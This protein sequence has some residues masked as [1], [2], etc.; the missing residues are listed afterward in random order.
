MQIQSIIAQS[1]SKKTNNKMCNSANKRNQAYSKDNSSTQL[2]DSLTSFGSIKQNKIIQK[3]PFA[4]LMLPVALGLSAL[5]I[6]CQQAT[7]VK[8]VDPIIVTPTPAEGN[9]KY[10]ASLSDREKTVALKIEDA[11]MAYEQVRNQSIPLDKIL[12]LSKSIGV[13]NDREAEIVSERLAIYLKD[14][15][16]NSN[17]ISPDR[18]N[19]SESEKNARL[20]TMM[21]AFDAE[22]FQTYRAVEDAEEAFVYTQDTLIQPNSADEV[23]DRLGIFDLT[24]RTFGKNQINRLNSS[25]NGINLLSSSEF[26]SPDKLTMNPVEKSDN[27]WNVMQKVTPRYYE[28]ALEEEDIQGAAMYLDGKPYG[29]GI[30]GQFE[31]EN[32]ITDVKEKTFVEKQFRLHNDQYNLTNDPF[33]G[34]MSPKRQDMKKK[35]IA[36]YERF[37]AETGKLLKYSKPENIITLTY[38]CD[39]SATI[40]P[41]YTTL[42]VGFN[43]VTWFAYCQ[44]KEIATRE[45]LVKPYPYMDYPADQQIPLH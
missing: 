32:K 15:G 26:M 39:P 21:K 18:K 8:P 16:V 24:Q 34:V 31:D 40:N 29:L 38:K 44:R 19:M 42:P 7:S 12:D 11:E 37:Y 22:S 10:W 13:Q 43:I 4:I 5:S 1:A 17:N 2:K 14:G 20:L 35:A 28:I 45:G 30:A 33:S 36:E 9:A 23:L 3:N 25:D 6:S 41:N 27:L